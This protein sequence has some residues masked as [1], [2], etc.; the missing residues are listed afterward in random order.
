MKAERFARWFLILLMPI[1]LLVALLARSQGNGQAVELR[2]RMPEQGGWAPSDLT[3]VAGQPFHLRLSSD[4]VLHGFAIGQ[5]DQ[6]A[7]D[8]YP[9]QTTGLTL[10]FDQPGKYTYYCTRW[11]GANHWRMRGTIEVLPN[12]DQPS[13][14]KDLPAGEQPLFM[15]VDVELDGHPYTDLLPQQGRPDARRGEALGIT[16]AESYLTPD[17]YRLHS[18]ADVFA[19]LRQ[20]PFAASLSDPQVWDLV[21]WIWRQGTTP[22]RLAEGQELYARNCAACHG[23]TGA[24]DGVMAAQVAAEY[25][26][27]GH[28]AGPV[29]FTDA[30]RSLA[31]SPVIQQGKIIRGGMGTGMPYWGPIF[32]DEQIWSLVDYLW[33][34]Q[35]DY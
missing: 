35:F 14:A 11:C 13:P 12:P 22:D 26:D 30:H 16:P 8:V 31:T 21:A 9:G 24:G 32:T 20:E 7:V 25:A 28:A 2:A 27:S 5:S 33:T 6:P 15:Q 34:F 10:Q 29:A 4:D 1:L 23:E 19:A 17:Y 18:P 3:A